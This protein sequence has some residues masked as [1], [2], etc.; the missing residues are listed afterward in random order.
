MAVHRIRLR[1]P[2][3]WRHRGRW[4]R[5]RLPAGWSELLAADKTPCLRRQFH[6]P[7][8][9]TADDKVLVVAGNLAGPASVALDATMIADVP[10]GSHNLQVDVTQQLLP[11]CIL[12]IEF[13]VGD[14]AERR[15]GLWESVSLEI[16]AA[17]EN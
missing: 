13:G 5:V 15:S 1:G 2:W 4:N 8:G 10:H 17:E 11:S 16:R 14:Q 3:E 6:R 12:M 7:T 9:L